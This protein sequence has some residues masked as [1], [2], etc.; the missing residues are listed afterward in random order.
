[1]LVGFGGYAKEWD[2]EIVLKLR[3]ICSQCRCLFVGSRLG[4]E[5]GGSSMKQRF[6]CL[7][8]RV[9]KPVL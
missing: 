5:G 7:C 9:S 8:N 2:E 3:K 4:L 1:M 6:L